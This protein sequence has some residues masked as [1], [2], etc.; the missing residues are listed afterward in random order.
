[1]SEFGE[2]LKSLRKERKISQRALAEKVGID[3]TYISKME[4][5]SIE[6]PAEDKILKMAEVFSVD[7]D[8][9]LLAAKKVPKDLQKIITEIEVAPMFLRSLPKLDSKQLSEIK[10]IMK[11]EE[12]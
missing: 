2:L 6:P 5:G 4:N 12:E 1:M 10:K 3:F 8:K 11:V 9:L 7:P